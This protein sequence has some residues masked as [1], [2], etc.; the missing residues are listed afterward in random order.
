M[1]QSVAISHTKPK[2]YFLTLGNPVLFDM[3][4]RQLADNFNLTLHFASNNL[5][6]KG[7]WSI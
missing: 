4:R 6:G 2:I 7:G 5:Q 1:L 3:A